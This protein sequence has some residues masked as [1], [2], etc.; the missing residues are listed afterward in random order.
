MIY[1]VERKSFSTPGLRSLL[2]SLVVLCFFI[3]LMVISPDHGGLIKTN[4]SEDLLID[5]VNVGEGDA[6]IIRT[7]SG[8]ALLVDGGP[9]ISEIISKTQGVEQLLEV[10]GKLNIKKL[11]GVVVT[12]WHSEHLLGLF[13]VIK[14]VPIGHIYEP[15]YEGRGIVFQDYVGLCNKT[16]TTR[17]KV[18]SDMVINLGKELFLQI[19]H[20]DFEPAKDTLLEQKNSSIVLMLRYGKVQILLT[21]DIQQSGIREIMKYGDGIRSQV[22]K[23]PNHGSDLSY[24]VEFMK[25]VGAKAGVIMTGKNNTLGHPSTR[26]IQGYEKAGTRV[27]RTDMQG[28]IRLVVGGKTENDF[29]VLTNVEY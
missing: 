11:Q 26:I 28:N 14:Y 16:K 18:H 23:I 29:E 27:Y 1:G 22:I 2:G 24:H 12:H 4:F 25:T 20:P 5:F 15:P 6:I 19:L 9:E 17:Q 7:P 10:L 8:K 13:P 21:G 3:W